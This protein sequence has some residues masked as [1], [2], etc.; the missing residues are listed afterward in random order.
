MSKNL[1][2][3]KSLFL[4]LFWCLVSCSIDDTVTEDFRFEILPIES[5]E[6]PTEM[7]FGEVYTIEYSYYKPT[8][9]HIFSDL[10]YQSEGNFRTI[11]V[12]NTVVNEIND[13]VCEPVNELVTNTFLFRCESTAGSYVFQ[14]WQGENEQ[15][16]DLY[17]SYEVPISN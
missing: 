4:I 10:Y 16:E 2:M 15:G 1:I 17:L 12:I 9:C 6:M 13:V 5:V 8:T 11:A 7:Q 14:F 3:K